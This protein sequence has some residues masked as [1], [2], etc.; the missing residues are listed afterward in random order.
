MRALW[1]SAIALSISACGGAPEPVDIQNSNTS[2]F[3][4]DLTSAVDNFPKDNSVDVPI[5]SPI[6]VDFSKP[7]RRASVSANFSFRLENE[8]GVAVQGQYRLREGGRRI[9]FIP[10][11]G[12]NTVPLKPSTTYTLF[13]WYLED[14]KQ[15]PVPP[16]IFRFRTQERQ[17]SPS[18]FEVKEFLPSEFLWAPNDL[19]QIE[20][21]QEIAPPE[22]PT[23]GPNCSNVSWNSA[24]SIQV[25]DWVGGVEGDA[26]FFGIDGTICR[27]KK[28]GKWVILEIQPQTLSEQIPSLALINLLVSRSEDLVSVT[29][30]Q[31]KEESYDQQKLMLPPLTYVFDYIFGDLN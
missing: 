14:E 25:L 31:L 18:D 27:K 16:Y 12:S 15:D 26:N 28:D 23:D 4:Q 17:T 5:D 10:K 2:R 8:L 24:F 21:N 13:A 30:G 19:I 29:G 1:L 6:Y 22:I 3:F 20:F 7:I 9:E 11:S